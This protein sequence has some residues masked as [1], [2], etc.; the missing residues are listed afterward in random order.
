MTDHVRGA[1]V[2]AYLGKG[3]SGKTAL[4]G[5][6]ARL[7]LSGGGRRVLLIDADP[8]LGLIYALGEQ[9]LRSVGEVR[10][11][12][13]REVKSTK[14][15]DTDKE[16]MSMTVDYLMLE[17][18]QERPG[19]SLLAMGR[20]EGPGCYCPVNSLLRGSIE[21]FAQSFDYIVVDAEAGIEQVSRQV[22][23]RVD[24]S[25]IV[26][27]S[28]LRGSETAGAIK[29][30]L[31][32]VGCPP[33]K[34]VIFN[35]VHTPDESL[36]KRIGDADISYLGCVPVDDNLA[37]FDLEGRSLLELPDDSPALSS[38]NKILESSEIVRF[39]YSGNNA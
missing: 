2:I 1:S 35:R 28:S 15:G 16:R 4:S 13:I 24:H 30:A 20:T 22:T 33:P 32:R 7:L 18:L 34:G 39:E 27:D 38:L 9:G 3:G 17:S 6:T 29:D 37:R 26:T 8:A 36:L 10:D 5:L 23:R 12:I 19:Y 31:Q 21:E 11:E 14:P 25:V